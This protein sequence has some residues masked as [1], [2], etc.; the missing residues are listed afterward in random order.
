MC[1]SAKLTLQLKCRTKVESQPL[2]M[3]RTAELVS[4]LDNCQGK[5]QHQYLQLL[6]NSV[7][8]QCSQPG[9]AEPVHESAQGTD[10][11]QGDL[12]GR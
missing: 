11:Q 10:G 5:C 6:F 12:E 8:Y 1:V 3:S 9:S 2:L 7:G 4:C